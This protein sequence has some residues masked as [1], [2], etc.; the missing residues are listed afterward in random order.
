MFTAQHH[1]GGT[2]N[3]GGGADPDRNFS[4]ERGA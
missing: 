1:D 3:N 4:T 2:D